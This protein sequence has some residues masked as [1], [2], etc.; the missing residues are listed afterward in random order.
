MNDEERTL[1]KIDRI[2]EGVSIDFRTKNAEDF[3]GIAYAVAQLC[4]EH[5]ILGIM[6]LQ[7]MG[8]TFKENGNDNITAVEMPDFNELLKN[9]K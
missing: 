8:D 1:L 6:L 5:C 9:I 3:A 4:K 7:A 2:E